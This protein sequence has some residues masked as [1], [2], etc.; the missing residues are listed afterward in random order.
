MS[1]KSPSG[2]KKVTSSFDQPFQIKQINKVSLH[3]QKIIKYFPELKGKDSF[4]AEFTCCQPLTD[5]YNQ[6][7]LEPD[8]M[9]YKRPDFGFNDRLTYT[10]VDEADVEKETYQGEG[11]RKFLDC[12]K[13]KPQNE[14]V[15]NYIDFIHK[16]KLDNLRSSMP[17]STKNNSL[18]TM[19]TLDIEVLKQI[20]NQMQK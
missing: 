20:S 5:I 13:I 19:S 16:K 1:P 7:K 18:Q 9:K 3:T 4:V 12:I 6:R 10:P 2:R 11:W 17:P 15:R 8:E 14:R